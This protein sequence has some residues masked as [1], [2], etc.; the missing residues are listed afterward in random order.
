L[1]RP[2][3]AFQAQFSIHF[4]MVSIQIEGKKRITFFSAEITHLLLRI[5]CHHSTA[6][7]II[8]LSGKSYFLD[9]KTLENTFI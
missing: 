6:I 3:K 1:I 9:F 4:E 5:R 7:E 8:L 2:I